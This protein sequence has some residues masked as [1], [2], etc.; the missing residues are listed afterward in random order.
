[1]NPEGLRDIATLKEIAKVIMRE[2][3]KRHLPPHFEHDIKKLKVEIFMWIE[4]SKLIG[5]HMAAIKQ[6]E[7]K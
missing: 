6:E 7:L 3:F 1:M 4:Q 5:P 2:D